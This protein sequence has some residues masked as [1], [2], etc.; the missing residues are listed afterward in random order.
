MAPIALFALL[1][2]AAGSARAADTTTWSIWSDSTCSSSKTASQSITDSTC[3]SS[4]LFCTT[5]G[6]NATVC[7]SETVSLGV[8]SFRVVQIGVTSFWVVQISGLASLTAS[9]CTD[10]SAASGCSTKTLPFPCGTCLSTVLVGGEAYVKVD[11]STV[12]ST[13]ATAASSAT[14][15]AGTKNSE[16]TLTPNSEMMMIMAISLAGALVFW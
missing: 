16:R 7:D 4:S 8:T 5:V 10:C 14:P 3:Y 2:A 6:L 15:A 1:A 11:C 13:T 9:N 12:A